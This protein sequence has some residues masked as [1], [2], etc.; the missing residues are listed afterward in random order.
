MHS[1]DLGDQPRVARIAKGQLFDGLG[2]VLGFFASLEDHAVMFRFAAHRVGIARV[3][4][5]HECLA[6]A[7]AEVFFFFSQ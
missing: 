7:A 3:P 5:E 4:R 6:A 2:R 1:T